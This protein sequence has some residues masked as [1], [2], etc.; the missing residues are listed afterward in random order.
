MTFDRPAALLGLLVLPILWWL[1]AGRPF[2]IEWPSLI[3]WPRTAVGDERRRSGVPRS[4]LAF[5]ALA[6][7]VAALARP[8][9]V[10]GNERRTIA[11]VFDR[12][13]STSARVAGGGSRLRAL[14]RSIGKRLRSL[15]IESIVRVWVTP[16]WA[17]SADSEFT[18]DAAATYVESLEPIPAEDD[19]ETV[20]DRARAWQDEHG[21]VDVWLAGDRL[22]EA[23]ESKP[24]RA[25]AQIA[26]WTIIAGDVA[27]DGIVFATVVEG[28]SKTRV[29]ASVC[30]SGRARPPRQVDLIVAEQPVQA[31]ELSAADEQT[32]SFEIP[33]SEDAAVIE[34]R[35]SGSDS[36]E[37]D[38]RFDIVDLP[39]HR[40]RVGLVGTTSNAVRRA[41]AATSAAEIVSNPPFDLVVCTTAAP[42]VEALAWLAFDAPDAAGLRLGNKVDVLGLRTSETAQV[43]RGLSLAGVSV[44]EARPVLGGNP[45]VIASTRNGPV[46]VAASAGRRLNIGF[47]ADDGG[48]SGDPSFPLLVRRM[49]G[50]AGGEGRGA[51]WRWFSTGDAVDVSARGIARARLE[52]PD[53]IVDEVAAADGYFRFRLTARGRVHF[54]CADESWNYATNLASRR[55]TLS[56]SLNGESDPNSWNGT[57]RREASRHDLRPMIGL[58]ALVVIAA[59]WTAMPSRNRSGREVGR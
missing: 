26:A 41:L 20:V 38:D 3:A 58:I 40:V 14:Q 33:R 51:G 55:E 4:W 30:R 36:M 9:A 19:L 24:S 39:S 8:F 29:D 47:D 5:V 28:S 1:L 6:L 56:P 48:W 53:G 15:P 12:S 34:L 31:R 52:T 46:C 57:S 45:E 13:A 22:P 59:A 23:P 11:L 54:N 2:R 21:N 35:L 7:L 10:S 16:S 17:T 18:R 32:V 44:H 27:N 37:A 50:R 42:P 43:F 49:I 25:R